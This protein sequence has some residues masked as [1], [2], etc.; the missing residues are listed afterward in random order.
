MVK[1]CNYFFFL[2]VK[3]HRQINVEKTMKNQNIF[4]SELANM[5]VKST[6]LI[7]YYKFSCNIIFSKHHKHGA[8]DTKPGYL[9]ETD[10]V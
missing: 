5:Y 4:F 3:S 8:I 7:T 10:F 6:A 9:N 1:I 2:L